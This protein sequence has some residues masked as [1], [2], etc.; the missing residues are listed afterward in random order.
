MADTSRPMRPYETDGKDYHFVSRH[1]MEKFIQDSK[2]IEV[3]EYRGCLYGTSKDSIKRAAKTGKICIIKAP[4]EVYM[5]H[6]AQ[7]STTQCINTIHS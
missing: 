7:H 3:G 4:E 1:T 2:F 5:F 6:T